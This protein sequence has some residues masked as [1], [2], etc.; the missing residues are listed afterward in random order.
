MIRKGKN[1]RKNLQIILALG[2]VA[3]ENCIKYYKEKFKDKKKYIFKDDKHYRLPDG[4]IIFASYH[5][6]PRNVNTKIINIK[7]MKNL[8]LKIKKLN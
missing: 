2:K 8:L 1:G 6:S 4:K 7:M 3:F 5:P